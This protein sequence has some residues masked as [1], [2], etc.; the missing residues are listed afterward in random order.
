M[1]FFPAVLFFSF[2][3]KGSNNY[4]G[5]NYTGHTYTGHNYAGHN[6]AGHN[7]TGHT[8]TRVH[9]T[10][11]YFFAGCTVFFSL[12]DA[13]QFFLQL[14]RFISALEAASQEV[15]GG[16]GPREGTV[17]KRAWI[18]SQITEESS[19]DAGAGMIDKMMQ[20]VIPS[21]LDPHRH[22]RPL[23]CQIGNFF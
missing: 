3:S 2:C 10:S 7:Y 13:Q 21:R 12:Q 22:H 14:H 20:S 18:E 15:A 11:F 9:N 5:H 8:Y 19:F 23:C 4:I 1:Q 6:Y 17:Q 16:R